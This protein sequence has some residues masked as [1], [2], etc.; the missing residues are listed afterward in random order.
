MTY[1]PTTTLL[2]PL[3]DNIDD[4]ISVLCDRCLAQHYD[5]RVPEVEK[6]QMFELTL[7]LVGFWEEEGG[8][9]DD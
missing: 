7:T 9:T 2:P 1:Y 4:I 3:Y 8:L 5:F 6:T